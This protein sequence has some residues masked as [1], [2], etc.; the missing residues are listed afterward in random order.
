MPERVEA[1]DPV[2]VVS[3]PLSADESLAHF[4]LDAALEIELVAAEPQVVDPVSIAFDEHGHL[5]VAQMGDY[6]WGPAPGEKP[7]SRI[8]RLEDRD[9][10]GYFETA[11]VLA[12][13]LLFV[14]GLAP[15]RGG[16]VVT[17]AGRVEFLRDT[18]GDGRADHREVWYEGFAE[19]NSQLRANHPRL[20]FDHHFYVANGLRGGTIRNPRHPEWPAVE[21]GGRDFRFDPLTGRCEA[22]S[23]LAQFGWTEDALGRRFVCSNRHPLNHVV[24]EDRY[25]RLNPLLAVPEVVHVVA[26]A[27]EASR[28]FPLTGA[29]T[30]STLHAGQFTAA[31]GVTIVRGTALPPRYRGL[32]MT[33][34][35]TGNL[36]HAERMVPHGATFRSTPLEPGREL[37]AS[38]DEWFR[39][40]DLVEGPDGALYVV[41]MYRAVIEHPQWM[42][43]ELRRRADLEYGNRHG[44]IYRLRAAGARHTSAA[45]AAATMDAAPGGDANDDADADANAGRSSA[46][47]LERLIA[48][49]DHPNLW[50]RDTAARL[51][52]EHSAEP[53]GRSEAVRALHDVAT[54]DWS[55]PGAARRLWLLASLDALSPDE[56]RAALAAGGARAE[57]ALPLAE[58]WL[59][60]DAT[61]RAR[62]LE[63]AA[64]ADPRVRFQVALS[65]ATA[66]GDDLVAPLARIALAGH[67]DVWTRRAVLVASAQREVA[68]LEHVLAGLAASGPEF[69]SEPRA[70]HGASGVTSLTG[71]L[72]E[73]AARRGDAVRAIE[74]IRRSVPSP[75]GEPR[76]L[77]AYATLS[78]L[79]RG[80]TQH[81][82]AVRQV[83]AGARADEGTAGDR[84]GTG[85]GLAAWLEAVTRA[86]LDDAGDE[87]LA[88]T[89]REVAIAWLGASGAPHVAPML[90]SLLDGP[91]A[92]SLAPSIL[93]ALAPAVDDALCDE[94]LVRLPGWT[95]TLRRRGLDA[96]LQSTT[97]CRAVLTAVDE[98]RLAAAELDPLRRQRLLSHRDESISAA[99][100]GLLSRPPATSRAQV[101][102]AYRPLVEQ[103]G[104]PRRGRIV[105][106]RHCSTCHRIDGIGTDVG[107]DIADSRVRTP[108]EL[109]TDIVDPNRAIDANY[110]NYTLVTTRGQ[111][112]TGLVAAETAA[113]V[114][115]RQPEGKLESFRRFEIEELRSTG[116]SLM[117]EGLEKDIPPEEMADLVSFIKNWRYLDGRVPLGAQ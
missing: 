55:V 4:Q 52:L 117:P 56:V 59:A 42:P 66:K 33:C 96:L 85:G 49:L 72:A 93:E 57:C 27:D 86:A 5:W 78:G 54:A 70:L 6:P 110:V 53:P 44:R 10:D 15:W 47:S 24:L 43:E 99:A 1:V 81:G 103:G 37:L 16:V 104:D 63:L 84:S 32:A 31:C 98:G 2:P 68:L 89:E 29:W 101:L 77:V 79:A 18:T 112:H 40:V 100:R 28:V 14:T 20:G 92:S 113:S 12:D 102:E 74:V 48:L 19:D 106:E 34:E 65:L 76:R 115:L 80:L 38:R 60:D 62:V 97:G 111:I 61:L 11:T 108:L 67:D 17:L 105:F 114:T 91:Q 71:E 9:G 109:L 75:S 30:T 23:G 39:P 41:D 13:D 95:P 25:L 35:P 94:L 64:D 21:L 46:T 36:V 22:V 3:R 45:D 107:P 73:L 58:R 7:R 69:C 50:H 87:E 116:L 51:L 83:A 26:A 88:L 82:Q 8:S 90:L